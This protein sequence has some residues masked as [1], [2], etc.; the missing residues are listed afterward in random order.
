MIGIPFYGRE[1]IPESISLSLSLSLQSICDW[2]GQIVHWS[3]ADDVVLLVRL[4]KNEEYKMVHQMYL[5]SC[6]YTCTDHLSEIYVIETLRLTHCLNIRC[7]FSSKL[8]E[9]QHQCCSISLLKQQ[10]N[11][12]NFTNKVNKAVLVSVNSA[13]ILCNVDL[14]WYPTR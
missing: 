9:Q 5:G 2:W 1:V 13:V 4:Q 11:F 14:A 8:A 6:W 10:C 7:S 12:Y 3:N